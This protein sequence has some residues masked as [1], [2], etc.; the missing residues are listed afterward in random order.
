MEITSEIVIHIHTKHI[1][2]IL[3]IKKFCLFLYNWLHLAEKSVLQLYY[4]LLQS[5]CF[6]S[7]WVSCIFL[8]TC[9]LT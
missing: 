5:Y 9:I 8:Y 3:K 2:V 6:Y 1:Y 7:E 4:F